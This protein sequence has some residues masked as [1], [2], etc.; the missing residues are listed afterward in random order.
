VRVSPKISVVV[1]VFNRE[2]TL[3]QCLSSIVEQSYPHVELIIVDGAS[4]DRSVEIIQSF[5]KSIAF[6]SSEPDKGIYDAWNKALPHATGDW[7]CFVGSDDYFRDSDVLSNIARHLDTVDANIDFAYSRVMLVNAQG[8]D[9]MT[10]GKPWPET[11]KG[12]TR[13]MA[14]PH[15][16]MMHRR[17]MFT[18]GGYF[19]ASFRIAGDYELFLREHR[20]DNVSYVDDVIAISMRQGGISSLYSNARVSLLECRRAQKR[21]G[22]RFPSPMWVVDLVLS[23]IRLGMFRIFGDNATKRI[24]DTARTTLGLKPY[25]TKL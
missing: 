13:G 17:T 15:P 23:D 7:V 1:A 8:Q 14:A 18:R 22:I 10:I 12:V 16:A 2:S 25:W 3:E 9:L 11:A 24:I 19:D 21:Y 6:W 5:D 4:S 20:I